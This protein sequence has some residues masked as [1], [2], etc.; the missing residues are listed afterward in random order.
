MKRIICCFSVF[1]SLLL[2]CAAG[3]LPPFPDSFIDNMMKEEAKIAANE[4][5][6]DCE[7]FAK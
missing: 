5:M 4:T 3:D 2:S 1:Y 7:A 6:D